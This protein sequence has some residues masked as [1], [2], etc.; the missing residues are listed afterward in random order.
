MNSFGS[1]VANHLSDMAHG[2]FSSFFG[3]GFG[4]GGPK[5]DGAMRLM[6][7]ALALNSR[8]WITFDLTFELAP[9]APA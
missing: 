3:I 9:P 5:K 7:A 8:Y 1:L 2:S 4:S 6:N